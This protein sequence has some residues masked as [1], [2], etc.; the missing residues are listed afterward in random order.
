MRVHILIFRL[1]EYQK[2]GFIVSFL[3]V[4]SEKLYVKPLKETI[5]INLIL[6][7]GPF[8]GAVMG[9]HNYQTRFFSIE[10]SPNYL[11]FVLQ[12]Q[13]YVLTI[14]VLF[15]IEVFPTKNPKTI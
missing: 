11:K 9:R 8:E 1:N 10:Y 2:V 12:K 15:A 4:T 14:H 5:K 6:L 3:G 7:H 13:F